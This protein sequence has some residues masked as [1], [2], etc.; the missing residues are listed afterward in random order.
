MLFAQREGAFIARH[1]GTQ[2]KTQTRDRM[3]QFDPKE[4]RN[5]T[6]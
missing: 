6:R 1:S 3:A 4:Q 2:A 5:R